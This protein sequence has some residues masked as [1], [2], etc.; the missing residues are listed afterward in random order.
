MFMEKFHKR[1]VPTVLSLL[2]LFVVSGCTETEGTLGGAA[3]GTAGG[4]GIGYAVGGQGG[5][6]L[7]GV[8]GGLAGG[9]FGNHVASQGNQKNDYGNSGRNGGYQRDRYDDRYYGDDRYYDRVEL[10]RQKRDADRRNYENQRDVDR[11][12]YEN[13][14]E[15]ER[16]RRD[17]EQQRLELERQ[18]I[19]LERERKRL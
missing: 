11:R 8:I 17:L 4:A 15:I 19:E 7:G 12:N 10:E 14:I 13:Q 6:A 3:V 9:A 16:Q 2:L 18:R 5:A 1:I